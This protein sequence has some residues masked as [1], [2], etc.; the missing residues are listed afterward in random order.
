MTATPATGR[1]PDSGRLFRGAMGLA[2]VATFIASVE[3]A[4]V[5]LSE[6]LPESGPLLERLKAVDGTHFLWAA[7]H[8]AGALLALPLGYL[9]VGFAYPS[10]GLGS[11]SGANAAASVQA[12]AHVLGVAAVASACFG[13]VDAESFVVASVFAVL[14]W[15]AL[16]AVCALH[17]T[18]TTYR[19][20][21]EVSGGNLAAALS[22][23]GLHLGVA[24]VVAASAS[25]SFEGWDRALPGFLKSVAWVVA[26]YPFRQVIVARV[27]LG[28]TPADLDARIAHDR[29]VW[30][31]GVEGLGYLFAALAVTASW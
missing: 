23:A 17:R 19:D 28:M 21:D 13:G 1:V 8:V 2:V 5:A 10:R 14:C 22:S 12:T 27:V 4:V 9:I 29:D 20:H 7:V 30:C 11:Q 6:R 15:V 31:G 3:H 16:V 24:L 18:V 26:L 25:G